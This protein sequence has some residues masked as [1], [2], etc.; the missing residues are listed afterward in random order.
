MTIMAAINTRLSSYAPLIEIVPASSIF[1]VVIA[2]STP[3]PAISFETIS[4]KVYA[5][6]KENTGLAEIR[7]QVRCVAT[8]YEVAAAAA[9]QVKAA[10]D[11]YGNGTTIDCI[12]FITTHDGY[13]D[14]P[15]HYEVIQDYMVSFQEG[16]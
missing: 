13:N 4:G 1:A 8:T 10:L 5:A 2:Q 15:E 3:M 12:F 6:M 11:R 9:A 16:A 14:S 7:L